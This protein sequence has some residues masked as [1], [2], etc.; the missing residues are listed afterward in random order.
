MMAPTLAVLTPAFAQANL[1]FA[2]DRSNT[3][4]KVIVA[5]L[6]VGSIY[7]WS[8]M[9]TK[10][11]TL[12]LARLV[13]LRFLRTYR[14]EC[15][16]PVGLYLDEK[17]FDGSPLYAVYESACRALS[18]DGESIDIQNTAAD[19]GDPLLLKRMRNAAERAAA[20]QALR[21]ESDMGI[22]AT[23][24]T[25]APFLG[26]LGTVWGVMSA[27]AGMAVTGSPTMA[28][29]APGVSGALLTT[30]VGLIVALPSV[31]GYNLLSSSIRRLC[32]AME[33]FSE[34]LMSD[35]DLYWAGR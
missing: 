8:I 5:L 12:R 22:L 7:A 27:F 24:V 10:M 29:L 14:K 3:A 6:F 19:S 33:N 13:S 20:D 28:D 23:A 9:V 17:T 31:I 26:L 2:F 11:R 34:E 30:V 21:M 1:V 4:G 35:M 15:A 18:A 25:A 16:N 32:V